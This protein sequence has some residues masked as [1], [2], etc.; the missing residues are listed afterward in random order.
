M[1]EQI[2]MMM[3]RSG[4]PILMARLRYSCRCYQTDSRYDIFFGQFYDVLVHD[5]YSVKGINISNISKYQNTVLDLL[6]KS[7]VHKYDSDRLIELQKNIEELA[8]PYDDIQNMYQASPLLINLLI[9]GDE[10][11][12]K[13][14]LKASNKLTSDEQECLNRFHQYTLEVSKSLIQRVEDVMNLKWALGLGSHFL[15]SFL[16]K[17]FT[18]FSAILP[19]VA[20][21]GSENTAARPRK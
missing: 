19:D 12:A 17:S 3:Y 13:D 6:R 16:E 1:N 5:D 15:L 14:Y 10:P 2:S 8:Y 7:Q 18:V 21:P 20:L 11:S 9:K 4:N